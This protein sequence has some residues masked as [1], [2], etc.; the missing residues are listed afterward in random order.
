MSIIPNVQLKLPLLYQD[1]Y[2]IAIDKPAGIPCQPLRANEETTVANGLVAMFPELQGIGGELEAGLVHRLDNGTSGVLVAARTQAQYDYLRSIWNTNKVEKIYHALVLGHL[3][4]TITIDFAVAHHPRKKK[5]M[6]ACK[7]EEEMRKNKGRAARTIVKP[8]KEV[9]E[10]TLVEINIQT[11]V[12]HQIRVH[13]A[14]VGHPLVGDQLYQNLNQQ[15]MDQNADRL[16]LH[17]SSVGIKLATEDLL[18]QSPF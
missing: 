10:N 12:R 11:G 17:L 8:I 3:D 7:T 14:A 9:E 2:L 4:K 6:F 18:I 16:M 5:K 15:K 13:L 1:S